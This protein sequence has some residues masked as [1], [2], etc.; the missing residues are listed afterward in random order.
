MYYLSGQQEQ[1][2]LSNMLRS[3]GTRARPSRPRARIHHHCDDKQPTTRT[4]VSGRRLMDI[5]INAEL[6]VTGGGMNAD[7]R[8][9]ATARR[10]DV[11]FLFDVF[12]FGYDS[13]TANLEKWKKGTRDDHWP[14]GWLANAS[15]EA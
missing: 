15:F 11:S 7:D 6:C 9:D 12:A 1:E 8:R 5:E 13:Q 4:K 2:Q 14:A 10:K 3:R